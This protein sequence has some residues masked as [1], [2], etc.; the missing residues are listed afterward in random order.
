MFALDRV[1]VLDFGQYLAG[2]Y[3]PM[4]LAGLGADVIKVEPVAG[5]GMRMV[6]KPFVGCQKGKRCIALNVKTPAGLSLAHRLVATADIV[7]HNMTKG[8]AARLGLDYETLR[9]VRPDLIYCNTYAYGES[10]PLSDWGGLDPLYQAACG[11]EYE[12]GAVHEGNPPLYIRFGMTD[13]AN[14]LLSALALLLALYHRRRTGEGQEVTTSLLNG[15]AMFSSDAVL[16]ASGPLPRARLDAGLHGTGA[17]YRLY[18]TYDGWLQVGAVKE[19]HWR[20]LCA[21]VGRPDL[22]DDERFADAEGRRDHRRELEA[23]L[24]AAFATRPSRQW[25]LAL[26]A[27]GVPSEVCVDTNEGETV[28]H[29][30]ENI[31]LGLVEANQH[32]VLG[33]LRQFGHLITL[34]DT[35]GRIGEPPPV[36]GQHTREVLRELGCTEAE[37][38]AWVAEGVVAEPDASYRWPC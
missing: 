22:A 8:V 33:L 9:S 21:V 4:I 20:A 29:D 1:R 15:A 26:E 13:T 34:S 16:T 31:R 14:A 24:E 27:A 11:L 10:G 35:P 25:W 28:L 2:P 18:R 5:D 38:D 17:L 23:E 30:E 12:A 32:P 3:G 36:L 7:H 6:A 37:I 19:N